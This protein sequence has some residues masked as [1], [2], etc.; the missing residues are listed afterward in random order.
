M[1]DETKFWVTWRASDD[2]LSETPQDVREAVDLLRAKGWQVQPP[3]DLEIQDVVCTCSACPSQWD[4][5]TPDGRYVYI[6]YR[7]GCGRI[8][9]DEETVICWESDDPW[10][11]C[12]TLGQVVAVTGIKVLD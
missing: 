3:C 10:G 8:D 4:A 1:D 7:N 12:M 11:G 5:R 6:R 9:V 2:N